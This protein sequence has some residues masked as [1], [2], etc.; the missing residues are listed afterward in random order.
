V[1]P[2]DDENLT[3]TYAA[4]EYYR[5]RGREKQGEKEGERERPNES[6]INAKNELLA[7]IIR[8]EMHN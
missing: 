1:N 3:L 2:L 8:S 6:I 7:L 4:I 5:K